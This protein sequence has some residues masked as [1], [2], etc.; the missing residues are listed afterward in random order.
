MINKSKGDN[1]YTLVDVTG[2]LTPCA[3]DKLSAIAGVTRVRII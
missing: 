3:H 1:A 2:D